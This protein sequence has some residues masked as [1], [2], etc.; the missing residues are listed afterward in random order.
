MRIE[1]AIDRVDEADQMV[2]ADKTSLDARSAELIPWSAV[3]RGKQRF[4]SEQRLLS[5]L[6]RRNRPAF[7]RQPVLSG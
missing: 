6:L 5:S 4:A 1:K 3:F 7:F 2:N